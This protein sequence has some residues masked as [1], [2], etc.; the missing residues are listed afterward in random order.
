M[1]IQEATQNFIFLT[2]DTQLFFY[3]RL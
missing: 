1:K 3:S 2:N